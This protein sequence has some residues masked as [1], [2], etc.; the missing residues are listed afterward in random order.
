M[1]VYAY[2]LN[3]SFYLLQFLQ[4][5]LRRGQHGGDEGGRGTSGQKSRGTRTYFGHEGGQTPFYLAI[6]KYPFN[7]GHQ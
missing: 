2:P 3:L 4:K 5:R 6:P 7:T 1:K